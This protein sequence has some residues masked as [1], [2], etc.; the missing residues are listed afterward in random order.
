[1]K[2]SFC[3][4]KR[5]V[6]WVGSAAFFL[7]VILKG[8]S[9]LVAHPYHKI[10][11]GMEESQVKAI[12]GE[13]HPLI[14]QSPSPFLCDAKL[15]YGDCETLRKSGSTYFLTFNIVFDT[16]AIIGFRENKVIFKGIGD[17]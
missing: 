8:F 3:R 1:M 16:Y 6:I 4:I 2:I 17:A 12:F 15:W 9:F 5:I 11:T 10:E 7:L 13:N 14:E